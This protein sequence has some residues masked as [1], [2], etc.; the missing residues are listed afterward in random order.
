MVESKIEN[1]FGKYKVEGNEEY[2]WYKLTKEE[3]SLVIKT[4]KETEKSFIR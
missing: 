3:L 2:E 4:L 1:L